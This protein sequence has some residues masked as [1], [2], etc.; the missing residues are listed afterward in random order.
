MGQHKTNP[1]AIKAKNGEISPKSPTMSRTE[2]KRQLQAACHTVL[3][4]P[5]TEYVNQ[6][7]EIADVM[8]RMA[9]GVP[10][11]IKYRYECLKQA[12]YFDN[13]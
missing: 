12:G 3:S 9:N 8:N 4:S 13:E 1:T 5:F 11:H 2:F 6:Q 10:E 7:A